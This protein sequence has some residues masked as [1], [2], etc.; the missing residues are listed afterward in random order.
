[1]INTDSLTAWAYVLGIKIKFSDLRSSHNDLLGEADAEAKTITLDL[2]LVNNSREL[3]CVLAEEIGHILFPPRPGHLAY[4]SRQFWKTEHLKGSNI[5]AIVAQD[6]R[7]ALTW[8]TDVLMPNVEFSRILDK[9]VTTV[10]EL[11]E[12]FEVE[13]WFVMLKI[14]YYRKREREAGRKVKWREIIRRT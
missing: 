11:A 13:P 3:K 5:K 1:M 9:G 8:A 2:S 14:G 12:H 4:H 6:E 7:K 10:N